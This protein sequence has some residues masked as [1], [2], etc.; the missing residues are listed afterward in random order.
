VERIE[1]RLGT[2]I[3]GRLLETEGRLA[4]W[5]DSVVRRHAGRP[6]APAP[7]RGTEEIAAHLESMIARL[8]AR[9]EALAHPAR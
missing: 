7:R 6:P 1:S 3:A 5:V 2:E 8:D 9:L 4:G